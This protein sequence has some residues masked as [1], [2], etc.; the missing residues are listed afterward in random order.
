MEHAA[1]EMDLVTNQLQLQKDSSNDK[2]W[3]YNL[4][5]LKVY[6]SEA[7]IER[8][9]GRQEHKVCIAVEQA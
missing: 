7:Q 6:N 8:L 1:L 5:H 9:G 4:R 3:N 2:A